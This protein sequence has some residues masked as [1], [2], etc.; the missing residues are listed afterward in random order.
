VKSKAKKNPK[1]PKEKKPKT[2][3]KPKAVKTPKKKSVKA[4]TTTAKPKRTYQKRKRTTTTTE[5]GNGVTQEKKEKKKLESVT[6]IR[7]RARE[8]EKELKQKFGENT[9]WLVYVLPMTKRSYCREEDLMISLETLSAKQSSVGQ[10]SDTKEKEEK[11]EN[12]EKEDKEGGVT[13]KKKDQDFPLKEVYEFLLSKVPKP[14]PKP[15]RKPKKPKL[16]DVELPSTGETTSTNTSSE[17]LSN[18]T[19]MDDHPV[20]DVPINGTLNSLEVAASVEVA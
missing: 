9:W 6:V 3:R 19:T 4:L 13:E 10:S 2:P 15:V 17:G 5:N 18:Q 20:A 8:I 1:V 14:K 12:E 7:W 11:G 16:N